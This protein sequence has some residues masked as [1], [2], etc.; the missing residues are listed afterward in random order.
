MKQKTR[1]NPKVLK[2]KDGQLQFKCYPKKENII[3]NPKKD[4]LNVSNK[5]GLNL[6]KVTFAKIVNSFF[7]SKDIR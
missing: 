1:K 6:I 7:K 4:V 3:E 5:I 2:D